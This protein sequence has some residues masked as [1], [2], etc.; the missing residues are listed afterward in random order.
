MSSLRHPTRSRLRGDQPAADLPEHLLEHLFTAV[1]LLDEALC[2]QYANQAAEQLFATSVAHLT[3]QPIA[4]FFESNDPTASDLHGALRD[5]QT[6]IRRAARLR[7]HGNGDA[8]MVDYTITPLVAG[9]GD[10]RQLLMELQ[11]LD[12]QMRIHREDSLFTA[13][14]ATRALVRGLAHEIKN[15]LAGIRG[16]AQLLGQSLDQSPL[17][18]FTSVI[19]NETDRLS[20]LVDQMLE[21]H[22]LPDPGSVNIHRVLERVRVIVQAEAG[23]A[24]ALERDY[25]PSLP[26]VWADTDQLVQVVLNIVRNA[27]QA[28]LEAPAGN[29]GPDERPRI[30]LRS[31]VLRQ[32]TIG[33]QRHRLVC[34]IEVE[35]N[36]P[37]IREDLS[38][39]LFYPMVTGRAL[40]T[41]LGLPI[42]QAIIQRHGGLI[43]CDSQ[44]GRTVFRI[45]IPFRSAGAGDPAELHRDVA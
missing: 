29:G 28:L 7:F 2:V 12:R 31:R 43:E 35:D 21:P 18:E 25:D 4:S 15:P 6:R 36:G 23:S 33:A 9:G 14:L 44:P 22:E 30:I 16:A 27:A 3:G 32:F 1:V 10:V 26:D 11:P 13:S 37:G 5:Q 45:M 42:A 17:N 19:I 8:S 40:G 38:A 20:S 41:G 39:T 24:L 34:L